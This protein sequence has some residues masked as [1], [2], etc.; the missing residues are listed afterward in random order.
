LICRNSDKQRRE[1]EREAELERIRAHKEMEVARLRAAQVGDGMNFQASCC[2]FSQLP[3]SNFC[4][5]SSQIFPNL[6]LP[7]PA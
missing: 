1:E 2:V 3:I 6:S 4:I 7:L 5:L